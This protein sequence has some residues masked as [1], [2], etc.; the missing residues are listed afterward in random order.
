M[1]RQ[2]EAAR[3]LSDATVSSL[4]RQFVDVVVHCE[5][6]GSRFGVTEILFDPA[7]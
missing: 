5:R 6:H 4:L 1:F 7:A 2:H 3:P